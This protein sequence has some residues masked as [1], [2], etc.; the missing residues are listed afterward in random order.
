MSTQAAAAGFC[1]LCGKETSKA[2]AA[3]HLRTCVPAYFAQHPSGDPA[4]RV[5]LLSV[6]DRHIPDYWL[7]IAVSSDA[8]LEHLDRFLRGIWLECCGHLSQ[9]LING[10]VY[11]SHPDAA[12]WGDERTMN[13]PLHQV[14]EDGMSFMYQYD[15]GDT[16]ELTLKVISSFEAS[17]PSKG[18]ILLARNRPPDIR[19]DTCGQPAKYVCSQCTWEGLGWLCEQCA[20]QHECGEEMLLPVVNSPRVGV[21]GYTGSTR[22]G[23]E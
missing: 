13:I 4:R 23:D 17:A 16:T 14:M 18:V 12:F 9:F 19:C 15:M 11:L 3:R 6:A 7:Y 1:R 20:Q 21:C 5:F 10:V 2:A 22:W 8:T